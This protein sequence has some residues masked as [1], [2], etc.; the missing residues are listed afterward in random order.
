MLIHD[1]FCHHADYIM[2]LM[3]SLCV[4]LSS[5]RYC[6][7]APAHQGWCGIQDLF[8]NKNISM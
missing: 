7:K 1:C 6:V 5:Q 2:L 4:F 3:A 8:V